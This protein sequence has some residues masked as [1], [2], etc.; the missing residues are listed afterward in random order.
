MNYLIKVKES[1]DTELKGLLPADKGLRLK[2][3]FLG[4]G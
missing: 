4:D 3:D 1:K 2:A